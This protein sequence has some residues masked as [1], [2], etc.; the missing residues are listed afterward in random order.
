MTANDING[1]PTARSF[2]KQI[3]RAGFRI[4]YKRPDAG[5]DGIAGK[6]T[7]AEHWRDSP[8]MAAI[9]PLRAIR[10]ACA[11]WL[12]A[13]DENRLARPYVRT[14]GLAAH[15][16]ICAVVERNLSRTGAQHATE[17]SRQ[18][19]SA[20]LD[21]VVRARGVVDNAKQNNLAGRALAPNYA[22]E[23]NSARHVPAMTGTQMR[24]KYDQERGAGSTQLSF[25]DWM[26]HIAIPFAEDDT[27]QRL[28]LARDGNFG[29]ST[30]EAVKY[31][32]PQERWSRSLS[33]RGGVILDA[34]GERYHTGL[35]KT[36]FSGTGWAI[37]VMDFEGVFYSDSHAVN[38]F[39][40]SSF[41]A[42]GP[43]RAAGELAVDGGRLVAITNKTG[44]YLA[45]PQELADALAVM[46]DGGVD[47]SGVA[48]NDPNRARG[49]WV[50]GDQ[51][52]TAGG[53]VA[54]VVPVLTAPAR[55][56]G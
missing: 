42:G 16:R 32:T 21:D 33:V 5:L 10:H 14:L 29:R 26:T 49:K 7:D 55:V 54:S 24:T 19:F 53:D 38:Q 13:A 27:T 50:A 46:R 22:L 44:H 23:R 34:D 51:A 12:E 9:P 1:L 31:C 8:E 52:L 35:K 36:A 3:G 2:M 28:G 25:D 15:Q 17:Q 20:A 41:F 39:H 47:L 18:N 56:M 48:V 40:H 37:Y 30:A 43:V 11:A 45:R 4:R 6:L